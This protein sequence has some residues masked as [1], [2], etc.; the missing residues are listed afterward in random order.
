MDTLPQQD[1]IGASL[2]LT[3]LPAEVITGRDILPAIERPSGDSNTQIQ[4]DFEYARGNMITAIE[5]G[6]EALNGILEVA[7]MSQHP[8]AYEVAAT[9]VKATVDA[10]KDLMELSK[11]KK[12]LDKPAEGEAAG[13]NRVTNNMFVGST[14]ELLKAL[15]QNQ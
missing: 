4:D 8:R 3:P 2:N 11:R 6:Q 1:K 10:S 12:D 5:K 15:K 14:A 7:G 13:P 9:L